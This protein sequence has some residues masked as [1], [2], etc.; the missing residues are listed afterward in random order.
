M[1]PISLSKKQIQVRRD[2]TSS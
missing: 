1:R 2:C